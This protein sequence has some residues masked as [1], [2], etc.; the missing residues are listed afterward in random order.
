[1][2]YQKWTDEQRQQ[3]LEDLLQLSK[4]R[5]FEFV[6]D[7]IHDRVP[8]SNIDFTRVLPR[9]ISLYIFSFLDPTSLS[10]AAQVRNQ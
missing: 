2:Q 4:R 10:R 5:Q 7:I 8:A 6:R 3:V 1:M 9:V